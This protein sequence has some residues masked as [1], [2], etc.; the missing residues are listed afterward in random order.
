M[1]ETRLHSGFRQVS[2]GLEICYRL[3]IEVFEPAPGPAVCASKGTKPEICENFD[4]FPSFFS[5]FQQTK[6]DKNALNE[7]VYVDIILGP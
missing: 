7:C 6:N 2:G 3:H 5:I 1:Y 4:F